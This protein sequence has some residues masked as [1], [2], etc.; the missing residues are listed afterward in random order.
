MPDWSY[1]TVFR[2]LLFS[3]RP[4][5]A[6]DLALGAIGALGRTPMGPLVIDFMGH[7][8][9][10]KRLAVSHQGLRFP[11]AVG[12]GA[13]IDVT[14]G[15]LAALSR[16]GFGFV[17][18]GPVT[19]HPVRHEPGQCVERDDREASIIYHSPPDNPG[20]DAL[21]DR[22]ARRRRGTIPLVARLATAP[23]TA[24]AI[25]DMRAMA[26]R[27]A[28]FVQVLGLELPADALGDDARCRAFISGAAEG[29]GA[30][31][32]GCV[33]WLV[34]PPDLDPECAAMCLAHARELGWTGV[35]VDGS[36]RDGPTLRRMGQPAAPQARAMVRHLRS[37]MGPEC[38]IVASG[39]VHQPADALELRAAGADLVEI[40][41]GLVFSGPGLPKRV[42]EALLYQIQERA[43][44]TDAEST[45]PARPA[46]QPWLW[47]FLLGA[48]MFIGSTTALA[49]AATRV[50][51]PYD[52]QL[53]GLP[54]AHLAAANPRLLPF[55]AHDR[56]ALAGSMVT[57]AVMYCG[58]AW[59][60]VRR[61]VHWALVAV[62]ASA[63]AGFGTFFLF[64]GFGYFDPFHA[65][66]TSAMLQLLLLGVHSRLPPPAPLPAPDLFETPAWHRALWGQLVF[67]V[68]ATSFIVA[69]VVISGVG[70]TRVFVPEDLQYMRTDAHA[71]GSVSPHLLP[72]IAHDRATFGGMLVAA[73]LVFLMSALWGFRRGRA[74][75]WWTTL[76]AGLPGYAAAIGVHYAV[77]YHNV[78]HLTPAF[79]GA[80]L[81][82]VGLV[83]SYSHLCAR[84][85]TVEDA[86]RERLGPAAVNPRCS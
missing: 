30:V 32:P 50:V 54:R 7:T 73:G 29:F 33:V 47:L 52:E 42:N 19:R 71:L 46:Q 64:L 18:L 58:L 6:R 51:L 83:L 85:P 20:V 11:T 49:I 65:F 22:L 37:R 53:V 75:L 66:V 25:D 56:V 77:G 23:G 63:F 72:L 48:S 5:L 80:T 44:D 69:G 59:F 70:I 35:L 9:P 10:D 3:V 76:A 17:E 4:A 41:S 40:D 68:Q 12:L 57:I 31:A 13:G 27:L 24:T 81:F 84:D 82:A 62:E 26:H 28:P 67:I 39:G 60:G 38:L 55:M 78:W 45:D 15:A 14:A 21:A 2:P 1:R 16:F 86:W 61:G 79:A 36:L 43:R 34:V 74:W 8:R